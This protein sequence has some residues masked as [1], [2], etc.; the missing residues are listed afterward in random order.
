MWTLTWAST[1]WVSIAMSF[2]SRK[3][4]G[5][6]GTMLCSRAGASRQPP[7]ALSSS[8]HFAALDEGLLSLFLPHSCLYVE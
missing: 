6:S 3:S 5:S 7:S 4:S 1:S 8:A 2:V